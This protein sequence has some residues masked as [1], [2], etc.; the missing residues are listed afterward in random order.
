MST[1]MLTNINNKENEFV[2]NSKRQKR[3]TTINNNVL[4]EQTNNQNVVQRVG[5]DTD[6][7]DIIIIDPELTGTKESFA[8]LEQVFIR[9]QDITFDSTRDLVHP[10]L[11]WFDA[12]TMTVFINILFSNKFLC[13]LFTTTKDDELGHLQAAGGLSNFTSMLLRERSP[14]FEIN[15]AALYTVPSNVYGMTWQDGKPIPSYAAHQ[16]YDEHYEHWRGNAHNV[17]MYCSL[18]IKDLN[19]AR[20]IATLK[21]VKV[22]RVRSDDDS[23][24]SEDDDDDITSTNN[25]KIHLA[26]I[27]ENGS[28]KEARQTERTELLKLLKLVYPDLKPELLDT[29]FADDAWLTGDYISYDDRYEVQR[30]DYKD[31]NFPY[32]H[33]HTQKLASLNKYQR[34]GNIRLSRPFTGS[35]CQNF[36]M[37]GTNNIFILKEDDNYCKNCIYSY[38]NDEIGGKGHQQMPL[39]P[40]VKCLNNTMPVNYELTD[41]FPLTATAN[42]GLQIV[43]AMPNAKDYRFWDQV[44]YM[45]TYDDQMNTNRIYFAAQ[46]GIIADPNMKHNSFKISSKYCLTC[47]RNKHEVCQCSEFYFAYKDGAVGYSDG[48]PMH[49]VKGTGMVNK[50][51]FYKLVPE[52]NDADS[53][54]LLLMNRCFPEMII[55]NQEYQKLTLNYVKGFLKWTDTY[56]QHFRTIEFYDANGTKGEANDDDIDKLRTHYTQ[57]RNLRIAHS[58]GA[59]PNDENYRLS[60]ITGQGNDGNIFT[61]PLITNTVMMMNTWDRKKFNLIL[62]NKSKT[63]EFGV[64]QNLY[65]FKKNNNYDM[66]HWITTKYRKFLFYIKINNTK[67]LFVDLLR[68]NEDNHKMFERV[69]DTNVIQIHENEILVTALV[70][71]PYG[72]AK[73]ERSLLPNNRNP[74]LK[75]DL[76]LFTYR[77]NIKGMSELETTLP[78]AVY[79]FFVPKLCFENGD[80]NKTCNLHISSIKTEHVLEKNVASKIEQNEIHMLM[81]KDME[82]FISYITHNTTKKPTNYIKVFALDE[83]QFNKVSMAFDVTKKIKNITQ[84]TTL[85][86]GYEGSSIN[87]IGDYLKFL[88]PYLHQKRRQLPCLSQLLLDT[89]LTQFMFDYYLYHVEKE[90]G[91]N[92]YFQDTH[93]N[94]FNKTSFGSCLAIRNLNRDAIGNVCFIVQETGNKNLGNNFYGIDCG[95]SDYNTTKQ[96]T[97]GKELLPSIF[98]NLYISIQKYMKLDV[99]ESKLLLNAPKYVKPNGTRSY[100]KTKEYDYLF[101]KDFISNCHD[102][103]YF[104]NRVAEHLGRIEKIQEEKT[105]TRLKLTEEAKQHQWAFQNAETEYNLKKQEVTFAITMGLDGQEKENQLTELKKAEKMMNYKKERADLKQNKLQETDAKEMEVQ[106]DHTKE[107]TGLFFPERTELYFKHGSFKVDYLPPMGFVQRDNLDDK[108]S[109]V[110]YFP[111][112]PMLSVRSDFR[113]LCVRNNTFLERNKNMNTTLE[114]S[115]FALIKRGFLPIQHCD[116]YEGCTDRKIPV[117]RVTAPVN[118]YPYGEHSER[119]K[120]EYTI[121]K[122]PTETHKQIIKS[123]I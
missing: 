33:P 110:I 62:D 93:L 112:C 56:Y 75:F 37:L 32:L 70:A 119:N 109:T 19:A 118:Y 13:E 29:L 39:C 98:I 45:P 2:F 92:T 51:I 53:A 15:T 96:S 71:S 66:P 76:K 103:R 115:R 61:N 87:N 52:N 86:Y 35:L 65:E 31:I 58:I 42:K 68:R 73:N 55:E 67:F 54:I 106:I 69:L 20:E 34:R 123:F 50:G 3:N 117:P 11:Q 4:T 7:E 63:L 28:R 113:F 82:I 122:G 85:Y 43:T 111:H 83:L 10:V 84:K 88:K 30:K 12:T 1:M 36:L 5:L 120:T 60:A 108:Q 80:W 102:I 21:A 105:Q 17:H 79:P 104:T 107:K 18:K 44:K 23:D 59:F 6:V 95:I 97:E 78:Y 116:N 91:M 27:S 25:H 9:F 46:T 100:T 41:E 72:V 26:E 74:Y 49:T 8:V 48:T 16:K 99:F 101:K 89:T 47:H 14:K 81:T 38:V 40:C 57:N 121:K 114:A 90:S 22:Q 77:I 94:E 64:A 24:A